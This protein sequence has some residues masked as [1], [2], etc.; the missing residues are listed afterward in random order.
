MVNAASTGSLITPGGLLEYSSSGS[1]LQSFFPSQGASLGCISAPLPIAIDAT[2][3]VWLGDTF[4]YCAV[5]VSSTG[6]VLWQDRIS[7]GLV[8]GPYSIGIDGSGNA[9]VG[10]EAGGILKFSGSGSPLLSG[11]TGG[12]GVAVDAAGNLWG[13]EDAGLVKL[14]NS[15]SV[16]SGSGFTGGGLSYPY[17][18]AVD[19]AGNVWAPNTTGGS[20]ADL[21]GWISE[22]SNSG[23]AISGTTGYIGPSFN[24]NAGA[25]NAPQNLAIDGS[26]DLWVTNTNSSSSAGNATVTE[27]IGAAVPVVTP[28]AAGLPA[29]PT[30][31]GSSKLGTRP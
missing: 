24:G 4:A 31:D 29:T 10:T 3:S 18:I 9:W 15:G 30:A 25:V 19:G 27:F 8:G 16:L 6:T 17:V 13:R 1:V 2:G 11:L 22:M 26:G 28:I 23:Q 21:N 12:F 5:K 20:G 7:D 14:S